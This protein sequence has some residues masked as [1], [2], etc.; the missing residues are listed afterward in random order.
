[1]RAFGGKELTV[2]LNTGKIN[3]QMLGEIPDNIYAYS[4]VPQIEVLS[5]VD[6]FFTH[7]GMNSI[8]EAMTLGVPM[9]AM[10]FVNDQI[11]NANRVVELGIGK[12][13]RRFQVVEKSY[14]LHAK[15]SYPMKKSKNGATNYKRN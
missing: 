9:V 4:F 8:N 12:K 1:M 6:L 3:P 2:I 5:N 7:C 15:V 11:S 13:V 10:P 14:M